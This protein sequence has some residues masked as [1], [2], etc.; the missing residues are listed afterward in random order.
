MVNVHPCL[1]SEWF[2]VKLFRE[3]RSFWTNVKLFITDSLV[4]E[5]VGLEDVDELI[6]DIDQ[7]W[8]C[9]KGIINCDCRGKTFNC[10][11]F[12]TLHYLIYHFRHPTIL[13]A[14][15]RMEQFLKILKILSRCFSR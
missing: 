7:Y 15:N 1:H 3:N 5:S 10:K 9:Q 4:L 14:F 11:K 8:K 12:I 2:V 13:L 6:Q